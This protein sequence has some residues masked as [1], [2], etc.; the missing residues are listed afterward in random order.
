MVPAP[1][2]AAVRSGRLGPSDAPSVVWGDRVRTP[3]RVRECREPSVGSWGCPA[4]GDGRSDRA[5][6][7][8]EPRDPT[9]DDGEPDPGSARGRWRV[10]HRCRGCRSVRASR[11]RQY[12][13]A[14]RRDAQRN[15]ARVHGCP[16]T[17]CGACLRPHARGGSLRVWGLGCEW[18][19]RAVWAGGQ[20]VGVSWSGAKWPCPWSYSS[21]HCSSPALSLL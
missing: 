4:R 13:G 3:D 2:A 21:V 9:V 20:R 10:W 1:G 16:S 12:S 7:I 15:R 17:G 8:E 18:R 19:G 14:R 6:R 11:A 5:R